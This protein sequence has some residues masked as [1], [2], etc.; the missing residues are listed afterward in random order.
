[1]KIL[2]VLAGFISKIKQA[3]IFN[4]RSVKYFSKHFLFQKIWNVWVNYCVNYMQ[5][6]SLFCFA[7]YNLEQLNNRQ[8][9]TDVNSL[10]HYFESY[11]QKECLVEVSKFLTSDRK[12]TVLWN[13]SKTER[14]EHLLA[15]CAKFRKSKTC[16][17]TKIYNF[18]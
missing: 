6:N 9:E 11:Y 5:S 10:V 3:D 7:G 12:M 13:V 1:M 8:R 16:V 2:S 4:F 14:K 17:F 18:G 15:F